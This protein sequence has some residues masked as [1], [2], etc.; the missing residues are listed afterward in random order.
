MLNFIKVKVVTGYYF[1]S[2]LLCSHELLLLPSLSAPFS[3]AVS[4]D[5]GPQNQANH[6]ITVQMAIISVCGSDNRSQG[7]GNSSSVAGM[8][9]VPE[10]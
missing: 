1:V 2:G 4:G 10:E 9:H 3:P 8:D 6:I 7:T 5:F